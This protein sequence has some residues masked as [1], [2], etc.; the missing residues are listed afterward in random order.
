MTLP[1]RGHE[2]WGIPNYGAA[3][4]GIDPAL[5]TE[6]AALGFSR[7]DGLGRP[8]FVESFAEGLGAWALT[9]TGTALCADFPAFAPPSSLLM[10]CSGGVGTGPKLTRVQTLQPAS[11]MGLEVATALTTGF[12]PGPYANFQMIFG[13]VNGS[14]YTLGLSYN[15]TIPV[16]WDIQTTIGAVRIGASHMLAGYVGYPWQTVKVVADFTTGRYVRALISG[17]VVD[18]SAYAMVAAPG[19]GAL[20]QVTMEVLERAAATEQMAIGYLVITRDEVP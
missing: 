18:L 4:K 5:V 1:P 20:A 11:I 9:G 14:I 2:D 16:G 12:I 17:A 10:T 8:V 6:Y 13:G 3:A 19:T 15:A 7:M